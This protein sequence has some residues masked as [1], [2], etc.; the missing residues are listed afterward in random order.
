MVS[1]N[2]IRPTN[3]PRFQTLVA[4]AFQSL[5]VRSSYVGLE[6]L[7][8]VDGGDEEQAIVLRANPCPIQ[9]QDHLT[10]GRKRPR[11]PPEDG[12]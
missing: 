6:S 12:A 7:E 4:C 11:W 5:G 1:I 3:T 2:S 8:F 9:Q 10:G